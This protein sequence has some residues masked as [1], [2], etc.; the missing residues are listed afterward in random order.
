MHRLRNGR[1][2]R[3][4]RADES[5]VGSGFLDDICCNTYIIGSLLELWH[6]TAFQ[7]QRQRANTGR[8]L[9]IR[10]NTTILPDPKFLTIFDI[11]ILIHSI[12]KFLY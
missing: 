4:M 1:K 11:Q 9:F 12:H 8:L 3:L 5:T 7:C 2:S 6:V 10:L